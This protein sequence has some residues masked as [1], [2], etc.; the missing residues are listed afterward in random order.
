MEI[1]NI[2]IG[3]VLLVILCL[4]SIVKGLKDEK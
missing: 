3:F 4:I 2:F 1:L